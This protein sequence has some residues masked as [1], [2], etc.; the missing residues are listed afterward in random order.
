LNIPGPRLVAPKMSSE[1]GLVLKSKKRAHSKVVPYACR[2]TPAARLTR[3]RSSF[4]ER[5]GEG[6]WGAAPVP[7]FVSM[8]RS[9]Q[10]TSHVD[11]C[12]SAGT[13][14]PVCSPC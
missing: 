4:C 8:Y 10:G 7:R 12:L 13:M 14:P 11:P 2:K 3:K 6:G 9:M 5:I 1:R